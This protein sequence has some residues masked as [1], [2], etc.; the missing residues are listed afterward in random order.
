MLDTDSQ[1]FVKIE[2]NL[3]NLAVAARGDGVDRASIS[4]SLFSRVATMIPSFAREADAK[5]DFA[6][7]LILSDPRP[8]AFVVR[9]GL[10][11]STQPEPAQTAPD[12]TNCGAA[13][14]CGASCGPRWNRTSSCPA[15]TPRPRARIP[16]IP[17]ADTDS[18]VPRRPSPSPSKKKVALAQD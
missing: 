10:V 16:G 13:C 12:G 9:G 14:R 17:P 15:A 2:G 7:G 4:D 3:A 6:R 1:C 8:R 18:R 11:E 5:S